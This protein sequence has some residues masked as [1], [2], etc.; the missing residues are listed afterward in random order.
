MK[1]RSLVE[2]LC[3]SFVRACIALALI[4]LLYQSAPKHEAPTC[5]VFQCYEQNETYDGR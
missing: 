2:V 4:G 3:W 1:R 5:L